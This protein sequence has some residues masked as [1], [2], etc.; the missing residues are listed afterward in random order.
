MALY[1][2][3][4]LSLELAGRVA[5]HGRGS[6][7]TTD[8][9]AIGPQMQQAPARGVLLLCLVGAQEPMVCQQQH[10]PGLVTTPAA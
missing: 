7:C 10:Q 2:V 1:M 6:R 9:I 4:V 8:D 5:E 3:G